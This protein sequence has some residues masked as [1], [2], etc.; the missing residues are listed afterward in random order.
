LFFFDVAEAILLMFAY[1]NNEV[2]CNYFQ[3]DGFW[4]RQIVNTF[5]SAEVATPMT[6]GQH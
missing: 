6:L 3:G 2:L 4:A 1:D 5:V